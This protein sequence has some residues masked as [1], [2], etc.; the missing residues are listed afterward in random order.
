MC[1][2]LAGSTW[3]RSRRFIGQ[4]KIA[5][6]MGLP[7]IQDVD[8]SAMERWCADAGEPRYRAAQVLG[9]VHRRGADDFATMSI[10]GKDLR[11][12]LVET[13]AIDRFVP[14][15]VAQAADGTRKLLFG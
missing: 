13:F 4:A 6:R 12:R 10:L 11:T 1:V 2:L 5:T 7:D 8:L 3:P 15:H 14:T 9:W